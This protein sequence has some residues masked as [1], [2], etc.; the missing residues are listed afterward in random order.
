M[1][2]FDELI[3]NNIKLIPIH[4]ITEDGA[5]TCDNASCTK[6]GKHPQ[7]KN[8]STTEKLIVTNEG[9][10]AAL[11]VNPN[12]NFG[13][14]LKPSK[15]LCVDIDPRNG[16]P[17]NQAAFVAEYGL[18]KTPF[19]V[20]TG[21]YSNERGQHLYFLM[22]NAAVGF[23]DDFKQSAKTVGGID[24]KGF[25]ETDYTVAPHSKHYTGVRYTFEGDLTEAL[26]WLPYFPVAHCKLAALTSDHAEIG[27]DAEGGEVDVFAADAQGF[28]HSVE[29][30]DNVERVQSALEYISADCDRDTWRNVCF[31]IA[32]TDWDCARGLALDWSKSEPEAF[33]QHDFDVMWRSAK[34][35]KANPVTLGTLFHFA[36]KNGWV[37]PKSKMAAGADGLSYGDADNAKRLANYVLGRM[38]H[39]TSNNTWYV[40]ENGLWRSDEKAIAR[41]AVELA[42]ICVT[43]EGD[44]LAKAR[45]SGDSWGIKEAERRYKEAFAVSASSKRLTA[46]QFIAKIFDEVS[47]QSP[48]Q[49]D[50]NMWLLGL[51]NGVFDLQQGR[52]LPHSPDHLITKCA[53][54]AYDRFAFCPQWLKFLHDVFEGDAEKIA[55]VQRAVGYTLCGNIDEEKLFL[56]H[57]RGANGK[58]V[59]GNVIAALFGDYAHSIDPKALAKG[60]NSEAR[61][62][63]V[64]SVGKRMIAANELTTSDVWDDSIIKQLA[65]REKMSVRELYCESFEVMPTAKLWIRTNSLPAAHDASDGFWRRI[66]LI[67]F[68]R[69]FA[70]SERVADLD[71][72]LINEE[73]SAILNWA[74]EGFNQW[75]A[76]GLRTPASIAAITNDYRKAT[77][78]IGLWMEDRVEHDL[79]ATTPSR[80]LYQSYKDWC[81]NQGCNPPSSPVFGRQLSGLGYMADKSRG[82]RG[83]K[84]LKLKLL[85]FDLLYDVDGL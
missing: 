24:L 75:R 54:A 16:N 52:L 38:V 46:M 76:I 17:I 48:S 66:A 44:A 69:Q 37:R 27:C 26:E 81:A 83:F 85:D 50:S 29:T 60:A 84:G 12:C 19:Q 65:S 80:E 61:A 23:S 10:A 62:A 28:N 68:K 59:F 32:S 41:A 39:S 40:Y 6:Q 67:E 51:P 82:V 1:L 73:L 15:L 3:S 53:G 13:I 45:K 64:A 43:T 56:L 20:K 5:C 11:Q 8:F 55:F 58:S 7:T 4:G 18:D 36:S 78:L 31:A 70:E 77:D 14:A 34:A 42:G 22:P 30:P 2:T 71:R 9:L 57:G 79:T 21:Q 74:I 72:K 49:F 25:G 35:D 47:I 33:N 63:Q